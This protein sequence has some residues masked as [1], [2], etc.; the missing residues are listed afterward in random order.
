MGIGGAPKRWGD[1]NRGCRRV[2]S[3]SAGYPCRRSEILARASLWKHSEVFL[4]DGRDRVCTPW[5][6][7]ITTYHLSETVSRVPSWE[8]AE[9]S[10]S[11]D[12]F[13]CFKW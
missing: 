13:Y 3:G 2:I 10:L 9:D 1:C 12:G 4:K 11:G 7:A 8:V 6:I 5:P